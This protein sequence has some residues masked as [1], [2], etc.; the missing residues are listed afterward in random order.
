MK[1]FLFLILAVMVCLTA[2]FQ[3]PAVS[4]ETEDPDAAYGEVVSISPNTLTLSQYNYETDEME[5]VG[6]NLGPKIEFENVASL[7]EI[8]EGDLSLIHI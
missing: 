6:Y 8:K 2:A 7:T 4:Q 5:E 3:H 1:K